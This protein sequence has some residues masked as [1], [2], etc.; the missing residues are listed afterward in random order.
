MT[1]G[2]RDQVKD[3]NKPKEEANESASWAIEVSGRPSKDKLEKE[4]AEEPHRR[5]YMHGVLQ[6]RERRYQCHLVLRW[7]Q[8]YHPPGVLWRQG[9]A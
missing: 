4:E 3:F 8:R 1:K 6:R 5:C 9:G 7:L 2:M